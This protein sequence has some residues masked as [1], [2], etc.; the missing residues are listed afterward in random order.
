M[1]LANRKV[2][3]ETRPRKITPDMVRACPPS[4][5]RCK[6]ACRD[7]VDELPLLTC[8]VSQQPPGTPE[9]LKTST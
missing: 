7:L 9:P 6:V 4:R 1:H 3:A 5:Q 2:V 8:G